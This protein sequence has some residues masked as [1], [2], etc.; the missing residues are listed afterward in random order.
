MLRSGLVLRSRTVKLLCEI[1][2][3]GELKA[4]PAQNKHLTAAGK[5]PSVTCLFVIVE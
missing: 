3:S 5:D 1:L 4:H 2:S